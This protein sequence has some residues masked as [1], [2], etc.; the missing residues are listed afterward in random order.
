MSKRVSDETIAEMLAEM[1]AKPK[2]ALAKK[3]PEKE[4]APEKETSSEK[5]ISEAFIE[6]IDTLYPEGTPH[7]ELKI[8]LIKQISENL[9]EDMDGF[10]QGEAANELIYAEFTGKQLDG[11]NE[12]SHL[13]GELFERLVTAEYVSNPPEVGI[14][15]LS[16]MHNPDRFNFLTELG[17]VRNPDLAT[18]E[19]DAE[20]NLV[21]TEAADAKLGKFNWRMYQ[22]FKKSGFREGMETMASAVNACSNLEEQGLLA[23]NEYRTK[24]KTI[25]VS[26]GFEQHVIVPYDRDVDHPES[27]INEKDFRDPTEYDDFVRMLKE[28]EITVIPSTFTIQEVT[29]MATILEGYIERRRASKYA[30]PEKVIWP[31]EL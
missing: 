27:L 20:N 3:S 2:E 28:E 14:E 6:A 1:G 22:Q 29:K 4:K 21:I 7:R 15:V 16:L 12:R 10:L 25:E 26:S 18:I 19:M 23:L 5:E 13:R 30:T 8:K 11:F 24:G 9:V 17:Y 31:P